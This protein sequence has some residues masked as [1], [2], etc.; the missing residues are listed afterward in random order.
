MRSLIGGGKLP[1]EERNI[2][3]DLCNQM[4]SRTDGLNYKSIA[5][6]MI[7]RLEEHTRD[8]IDSL[9]E[10]E[11]KTRMKED[12]AMIFD[13][14]QHGDGNHI[15]RVNIVSLQI[16]ILFTV[17]DP[18]YTH[19]FNNYNFPRSDDVSTPSV[20]RT[21]QDLMAI[22]WQNYDAVK[23]FLKKPGCDI[24]VLYNIQRETPYFKDNAIPTSEQ[25][26][27]LITIIVWG[28]PIV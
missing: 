22:K 11:K 21:F 2:Y 20:V 7:K 16:I 6:Q 27:Y 5:D 25:T 13:L 3:M 23:Q 17:N 28:S 4:T 1:K 19:D 15:G 24:G 12:L 26:I 9:D 14:H 8:E 18:E 10:G